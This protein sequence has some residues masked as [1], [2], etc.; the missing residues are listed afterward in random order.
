MCVREWEREKSGCEREARERERD[1]RG[2]GRRNPDV[3]EGEE[4]Q[5]GETVLIDRG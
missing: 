3:R 2:E 4:G 1:R 5:G